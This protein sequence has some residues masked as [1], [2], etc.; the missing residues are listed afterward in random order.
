MRQESDDGD[1]REH[2]FGFQGLDKAHSLELAGVQVHDDEVDRPFVRARHEPRKARLEEDV[3]LR[4]KP[5]RRDA[6][7]EEEIR[8]GRDD[9]HASARRRAG[10][11]LAPRGGVS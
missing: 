6:R 10:K 2:R 1:V 4:G 11:S 3:G 7:L 8:D 5:S 9:P